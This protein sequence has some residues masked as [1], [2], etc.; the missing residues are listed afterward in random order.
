MSNLWGKG[1]SLKSE[2]IFV[3]TLYI[4]EHQIST[5]VSN[6]EVNDSSNLGKKCCIHLLDKHWN[7]IA[8]GGT[9][10]M[11]IITVL[12]LRF[13]SRYSI[14]KVVVPIF[15][16]KDQKMT[17]DFSSAVFQW[18]YHN[19]HIG[20]IGAKIKT[21]KIPSDWTAGHILLSILYT[22]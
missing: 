22:L 3:P 10:R 4:E 7:G 12:A 21:R 6:I 8:I 13:T 20:E 2:A 19:C 16:I 9:L 1:L 17:G 11:C 18:L 15:G 14:Y 5:F